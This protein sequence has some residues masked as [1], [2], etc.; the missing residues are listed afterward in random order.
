MKSE[1]FLHYIAAVKL[2]AILM[3]AKISGSNPVSEK[4]IAV[5]IFKFCNPGKELDSKRLKSYIGYTHKIATDLQ[6]RTGAI[7][8]SYKKIRYPSGRKRA[9]YITLGKDVT[10]TIFDA[11][12]RKYEEYIQ[13]LRQKYVV[14]SEL[15]D[16]FVY[17][18]DKLYVTEAPKIPKKSS[19]KGP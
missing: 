17:L 13:E 18:L 8:I 16:K 6:Q 14:C 10:K 3:D 1:N 2:L 15:R 4:E 11:I 7:E 5:E 19:K 9:L 12:L